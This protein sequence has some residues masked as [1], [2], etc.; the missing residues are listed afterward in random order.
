[1]TKPWRSHIVTSVIF[2]SIEGHD[3]ALPMLKGQ[4]AKLY[5]LK[6]GVSKNS[7]IYFK[8]TTYACIN[9][10]TCISIYDSSW[11]EKLDRPALDPKFPLVLIIG[12]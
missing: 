10:S 5:L 8:A 2:Y 11:A 3:K 7:Q 4:R 6:E 9:F 1:M 12:P